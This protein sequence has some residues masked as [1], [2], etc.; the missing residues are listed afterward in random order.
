MVATFPGPT[1]CLSC[2]ERL[3]ER[4]PA[5]KVANIPLGTHNIPSARRFAGEDLAVPPAP[6]F[7]ALDRAYEAMW[8]ARAKKLAA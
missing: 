7:A 6:M 5:C 2:G 3:Y 1:E 8:L 4:M